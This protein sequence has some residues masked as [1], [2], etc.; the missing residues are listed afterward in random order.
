[1]LA[2]LI[3][4]GGIQFLGGLLLGLSLL[5]AGGYAR[6]CL[7]ERSSLWVHACPDCGSYDLERARR[8]WYD[9]ALNWIGIPIRRYH[10]RKC[11]WRGPRFRP[12]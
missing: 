11:H 3:E 1:V 5:G 2:W 9:R 8:R 12:N 6:R 10:C 4:D 7:M